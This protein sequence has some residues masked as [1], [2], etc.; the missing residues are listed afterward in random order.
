MPTD[1]YHEPPDELP[2]ETRTFARLCASL[3]EEAEA[4]GWYQQRLAV[5]PD[6]EARAIMGDAQGEEFKHFTHGPGV[7]A[8]PHAALARDRRSGV[9]FQDGDIV[10]HGEAAEEAATATRTTAGGEPTAARSA[11]ARSASAACRGQGSMN[12]LL[13][14]HAPITERAGSC[15]TTRR[16]SASRPRSAARRLVDF[17]GPHGWEHSAT[18]LGRVERGRRAAR[19]RASTRRGAACCRWSSCAPRSRSPAPSCATTT[20]APTTSTS[21]ALDEAAQRI[22]RGRERGRLPRLGRGRRSTG[23]AEASP[24]KPIPLGDDARRR[25]RAPWPRPSSCCCATRRRRAL[26]AR[27]RPRRVHARGRDGRA[28]RL[29]AASITC[30]RSSAARSSGRPGVKGAVVVS[31]RG[32]DFLFESR[33]GPLDRLRAPRRRGGPPLPG[34]VVQL[35][36]RDARGGGRA[37]GLA[38]RRGS[39]TVRSS[40]GPGA[41]KDR[42][43]RA[44]WGA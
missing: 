24:H 27:A 34:G 33:P 32:G 12:H 14:G 18:N 23:I 25:T 19:A 20:A 2:A 13:R 11:T 30:A 39:R 6:P 15:S 43:A 28:R 16:A 37:P 22:A 38:P 40:A 31:L 17:S 21:T 5:E 9:L 35:P 4:I 1:Q 8:A 44:L 10:E 41:A 3:T 42:V 7:P 26:R 29:P 36:R